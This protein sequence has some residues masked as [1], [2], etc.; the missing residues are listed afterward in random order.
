M[1]AISVTVGSIGWVG[2]LG[3]PPF[4]KMLRRGAESSPRTHLNR[5]REGRD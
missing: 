5:H 4:G 3:R 1:F 2:G